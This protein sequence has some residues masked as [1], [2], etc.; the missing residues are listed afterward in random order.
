MKFKGTITLTIAFIGI[1]LYYFLID[2]P[3]AERKREDKIRSEKVLL[4]EP[5]DVDT[6]SII[7]NKISITLKRSSASEWQMTAPVNAKGDTAAASTYLSFLNN[8]SFTRVV[9]D[10]PKDLSIFGLNTPTLKIS[11]SMKNGGTQGIRVGDDHPMGSKIYLARSD[12]NTV[13]SATVARNNLDRS[14]YDLRDKTILSFETSKVTKLECTRDE[15]TLVLEKVEASWKLSEEK[16]SAKGSENEISNFL[17]S[18]RAARIKEFVEEHPE[19]LA[20][21]GLDNPKLIL[22]VISAKASDPLTLLIGKKG[23]NG[24]YA[25]ILSGKN[26]FIIE[27]SLF[28]T[29]NNSRLVDFADKSLVNFS[30][31]EVAGLNLRMDDEAIHLIRD[32][33]DLQKWTIEKPVNAQA[34]TA[35]VNSLLF[36]LKD[37]RIV[38]FV[39]TFVTNPEPFGFDP[40]EKKL[41]LTYKDGKTWSLILGNQTSSGEHY[42]ARRTGEEVVFTLKRS[43]METIFRSLNDLKDKTLL[44]FNKDEVRQI[45]ILKPEQTFVLKKF[46]KEWNLTLPE[47]LDAVPDFIANDI[48][49][50]LNSL[51][52]ESALSTD[53]GDMITGLG[54]PRLAVELLDKKDRVLAHMMVGGAVAKSPDLYY[55]QTTSN[56]TIYTVNKRI[57]SEIP[58]NINKFKVQ[59]KSE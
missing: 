2:V 41:T 33:K 55:I 49:W 57:L 10:S 34:S 1:V 18:I 15:K 29:L 35:T 25:K 28:N 54:Q 27:Q 32:E 31:D 4:F 51:E 14:V 42:F 30:D 37:T 47:K 46:E 16:N 38:E 6:F 3:T 17:N 39:K 9:D 44:E 22:K 8:L 56:P 48:L 13:L 50:T 19:Q 43:S 24:F 40:A 20:S 23:E 5:G 26:V 52:F 12:E 53:P 45:K 59:S 58:G 11:F 36:D 7:K 21:Y